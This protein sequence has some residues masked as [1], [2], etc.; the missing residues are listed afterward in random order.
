[1]QLSAANTLALLAASLLLALGF[2]ISSR[3][4]HLN[5][6]QTY[7]STNV[8]QASP[9]IALRQSRSIRSVLSLDP[10]QHSSDLPRILI[11]I[12]SGKSCRHCSPN[13][14][15]GRPTMPLV[16]VGGGVTVAAGTGTR[17]GD[18]ELRQAVLDTW[19]KNRSEV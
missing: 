13:R 12:L 19:A 17:E 11:L 6:L 4:D 8:A 15:V 1:M 14:R 16:C 5:D 2:F 3:G 18:A 9:P 7:I 10:E